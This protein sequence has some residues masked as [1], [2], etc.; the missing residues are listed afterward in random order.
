[1]HIH[2]SVIIL[3]IEICIESRDLGSLHQQKILSIQLGKK[4]TLN[5]HIKRIKKDSAL[6]KG[7]INRK[8]RRSKKIIYYSKSLL[9]VCFRLF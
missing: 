9:F 5:D 4:S 3:S 2:L 8:L 1:M 6:L 7:E